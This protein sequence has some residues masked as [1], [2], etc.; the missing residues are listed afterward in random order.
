MEGTSGAA[1]RIPLRGGEREATLVASAVRNGVARLARQGP[2]CDAHRAVESGAGSP[3]PYPLRVG[4]TR[5]PGEAGR[6]K[7][8]AASDRSGRRR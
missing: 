8:L 1:Y 2:S 6:G 3:G 5:C 4:D 7:A